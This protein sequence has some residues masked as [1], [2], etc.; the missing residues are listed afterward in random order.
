MKGRYTMSFLQLPHNNWR[1]VIPEEVNK[2]D[3]VKL[4]H[5]VAKLYH[6]EHVLPEQ[7]AIFKALQLT[8][9]QDVK[10]VILGQDPYPNPKNAMGMSFSVNPGVSVPM[11]LQNIFLERWHDLGIPISHSGDLTP[12]AKQGVLL[13]NTVLTVR[14]GAS[15]SHQNLGWEEFTDGVI[16]ALNHS[17]QP[18]V[19]F[20]WGRQAQAKEDLIDH[21]SNHLIIKSSHPSPMSARYSFFGS[22]PFSQANHF[23]VEHGSDPINWEN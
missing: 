20:L 10:V 17:D 1:K 21:T 8:D 9:Y 2:D 15:A 14:A 13:L 12:W 4:D 22:Y 3:M 6:D 19:Y 5:T 18:V 23:L 11:S 16:K 7:N